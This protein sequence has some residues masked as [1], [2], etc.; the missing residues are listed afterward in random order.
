MTNCST[1]TFTASA[2]RSVALPSRRVLR[3]PSPAVKPIRLRPFLSRITLAM[4]H[5]SLSL[6]LFRN[7]QSKIPEQNISGFD[8][9]GSTLHYPTQ[10]VFS[11]TGFF[12]DSVSSLTAVLD[13]FSYSLNNHSDNHISKYL[14]LQY[15][16]V[17][18][19]CQVYSLKNFNFLGHRLHLLVLAVGA[20]PLMHP[21][22]TARPSR[23]EHVAHSR[24][25]STAKAFFQICLL[26]WPPRVVSSPNMVFPVQL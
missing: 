13:M 25:R 23:A 19:T 21:L 2:C 12:G 8:R 10:L 16:Q 7:C 1:L 26:L 15:K 6:A 18:G 3:L 22:D 17:L 24:L 5:L 20:S 14:H 9:A 11:N 4:F